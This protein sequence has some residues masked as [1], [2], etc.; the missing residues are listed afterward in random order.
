[1]NIFQFLEQSARRFPGKG[2]VYDGDHLFATYGELHKRSAAIAAGMLSRTNVGARVAIATENRPELIEILFAIW[3]A[4]M[5]A[6]PIDAQLGV[7]EMSQILENAEINILFSSP[8]LSALLTAEYTERD[9]RRPSPIV[10]GNQL[11]RSL[12]ETPAEA[13]GDVMPDTVAWLFYGSSA[14][15]ESKGAMLTHRNLLA[16]TTA[17][18]ADLDDVDETCSFIHALPMSH[19]SGLYILP[20]VA[21]AARNVVPTSSSCDPDEFLDLSDAHPKC[22]TYLT[23]DMIQLIG[24]KIEST[25]RRPGSI[26]NIIYAGEPKYATE[27]RKAMS[28]FGPKFSQIYATKEAPLTIT[29]LRRSDHLTDDLRILGSVGYPRTGVELRVVAADGHAAELGE[30]GEILC[31]SEVVMKGYWRNEVATSKMLHDG[32]LRTGDYGS[33]NEGGYVTLSDRPMG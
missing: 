4:G 5:V 20:Y 23:F 25:G 18:L 26:R 10:I 28:V 16:M 3:A 21:R 24:R 9:K 19:R 17:H 30:P 22:G 6:V 15:E 8:S 14:T 31:R 11:Y 13:I 29:G 7:H 27:L 33:I 1:M 12:A 2:A 32:W